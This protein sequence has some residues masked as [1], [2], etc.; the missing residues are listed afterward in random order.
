[1]FGK[2]IRNGISIIAL[3]LLLPIINS[4]S[5]QQ[6][7]PPEPQAHPQTKFYLGLIPE[8]DLFSQK[9]RYAPLAKEI[10]PF[11]KTNESATPNERH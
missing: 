5:D 1:M 4:C 3:F 7:A 8:Q 6:E 10:L 2:P 11:V 9:E